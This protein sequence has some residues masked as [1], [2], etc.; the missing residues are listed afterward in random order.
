MESAIHEVLHFITSAAGIALAFGMIGAVL[1]LKRYFDIPGPSEI[2]EML[3]RLFG[4]PE[5]SDD[6]HDPN[7]VNVEFRDTE[8]VLLNLGPLISVTMRNGRGFT[9]RIKEGVFGSCN[10]RWIKAGAHVR[11][12]V[13]E[14][15]VFERLKIQLDDVS[16]TLFIKSAFSMR[17]L[18]EQINQDVGLRVQEVPT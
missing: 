12:N 4:W 16:Q 8:G 9:Y 11:V 7:I 14:G 10:G 1:A 17:A 2:G 3:R 15:L 18:I 5:R 6:Y 13:Q